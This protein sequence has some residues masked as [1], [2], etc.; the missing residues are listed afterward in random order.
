MQDFPDWGKPVRP[1]LF[2]PTGSG[3]TVLATTGT[4]VAIRAATPSGKAVIKARRANAGTVYLGTSTVT[5][6]EDPD[7]G[8]LQLD[9][10]DFIVV[11]GTN[12]GDLWI[13]GAAGDGVSYAW[14][15]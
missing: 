15:V 4:A 13:D 10:G 5:D 12:L 8:G 2:T 3:V 1:T 7:T 9:P 6:D 14:W 11:S